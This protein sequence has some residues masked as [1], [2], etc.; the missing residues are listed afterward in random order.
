M[1]NLN[2]T[3][4]LNPQPIAFKCLKL[5]KYLKKICMTQMSSFFYDELHPQYPSLLKKTNGEAL[6]MPEGSYDLN[7]NAYENSGNMKLIVPAC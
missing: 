5:V 2:F 3:K 7:S 6:G 1:K 4:A